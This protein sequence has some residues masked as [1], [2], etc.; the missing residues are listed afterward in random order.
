MTSMGS[1]RSSRRGVLA[2]ML[3]LAAAGIMSPVGAQEATPAGG[4]MFTDVTG[5]MIERSEQ[6]VR[7]AAAIN[8]AAALWDFGVRPVAVFGWTAMAFPD[9][10]HVAWG[11]IDVDAVANV[12]A[13]D[14]DA[15]DVEK[16]IAANP[17][18]IVT[19]IWDKG[20]PETSM[21][22]V[23]AEVTSR[24]EQK[25]PILIVNRGDSNV[26]ELERI[27]ALAAALGA[28]LNAESLVADRA[29][30]RA[31]EQRVRNA[32]AAAPDVQVLF[33]SFGSDGFWVA[34]PDYVGDLGYV[35]ELG[36]TLANDGAP[37]SN[38]YWEAISP[39]QA[40]LYP[41]DLIYID[42]Y[43]EWTT[44][45]QLR[46]HPTLG[47]HPAVAAGQVAPWNR[48]LPLSYLGQTQYLTEV[49]EPF[50]QATKVA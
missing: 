12:S 4:W 32:A 34:G 39:E 5:R 16:L 18:L 1:I 25:A 13:N 24:V 48:D 3:G 14:S 20:S 36:M 40:L 35:R 11:R 26:V 7:V 43:G 29:A 2:G 10:D 19:W 46:A 44:L 23:P 9:G 21:V 6:P 38:Q 42:M 37:G 47:A 28:D 22:G 41:A 17:D 49:V 15:V 8:T 27:E 45:E 33:A 50:E 31:V 30:L